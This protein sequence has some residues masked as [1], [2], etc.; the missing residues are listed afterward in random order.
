MTV[1]IGVGKKR[2]RAAVLLDEIDALALGFDKVERTALQAGKVQ[3]TGRANSMR[4]RANE[5]AVMIV[6]RARQLRECLPAIEES[7]R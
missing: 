6:S 3:D 7:R 5:L 1:V 4:N 2:R